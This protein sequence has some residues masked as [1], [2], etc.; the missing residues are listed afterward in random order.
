[1][2]IIYE[3]DLIRYQPPVTKYGDEYF[4]PIVVKNRD[5]LVAFQEGVLSAAD[6]S[7]QDLIYSPTMFLGP[8][9]FTDISSNNTR[10]KSLSRSK[11]KEHLIEVI[12]CGVNRVNTP[13]A[14]DVNV[15]L[16]DYLLTVSCTCGN[17]FGFY[18]SFDI[19]EKDLHCEI[20][21]KKVIEYIHVDD[22]EIEFDGL[23]QELYVSLIQEIKTELGE[24]PIF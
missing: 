3:N 4:V 5:S 7:G 8:D 15:N 9:R 21:N 17:F 18:D 10:L 11:L 23:D 2:P 13:H 12:K 14:D 24:D 6:L 16:G 19:P 20:C 22:Y 1:M